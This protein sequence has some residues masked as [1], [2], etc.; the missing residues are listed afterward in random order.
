MAQRHD[1]STCTDPS[2]GSTRALGRDLTAGRKSERSPVP[3]PITIAQA[4][5]RAGVSRDTIRRRIADG[6]LPAV[7]I[8]PRLIRI[9]AADVDALMRPIPA[10][11][12]GRVA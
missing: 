1:R 3:N 6:T 7:R 5:E 4:A 8:G 11:G 9:D 10:A 2:R 12:G